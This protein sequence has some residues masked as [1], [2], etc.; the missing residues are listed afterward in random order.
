MTVQANLNENLLFQQHLQEAFALP[1]LRPVAL[2]MCLQWLQDREALLKSELM[3]LQALPQACSQPLRQ[4][5]GW[6]T[7]CVYTGNN[8]VNVCVSQ[9]DDAYGHM[10]MFYLITK[11]QNFVNCI[12]Q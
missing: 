10:H 12:I 9:A 2:R 5:V 1:E 11:Q 3:A 8:A 4:K 7:C 6:I